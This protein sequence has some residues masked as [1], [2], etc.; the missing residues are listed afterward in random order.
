MIAHALRAVANEMGVRFVDGME[1][2]EFSQPDF[3]FVYRPSL[4]G[5]GDYFHMPDNLGPSRSIDMA[6]AGIRKMLKRHGVEV[7]F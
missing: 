3:R 1:Q 2:S 6:V 5:R 7:V 4:H